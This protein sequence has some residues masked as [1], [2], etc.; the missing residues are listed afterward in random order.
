MTLQQYYPYSE[1]NALLPLP[2][3]PRNLTVKDYR[4]NC[5]TH[6][7]TVKHSLSF[8]ILLLKSVALLEEKVSGPVKSSDVK[9]YDSMIT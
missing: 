9:P 8:Q 3:P 6:S 7:H 5:T 2:P 1:I 4:P